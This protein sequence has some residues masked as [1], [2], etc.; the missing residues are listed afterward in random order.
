MKISK[1]LHI[2]TQLGVLEKSSTQEKFTGPEIRTTGNDKSFRL[3]YNL[4]YYYTSNVHSDMVMVP[5]Y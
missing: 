4:A 1:H 3:N 2:F 5:T